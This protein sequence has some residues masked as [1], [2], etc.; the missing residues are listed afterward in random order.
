M[1]SSDSRKLV[2]ST[3]AASAHL[4]WLTT[5]QVAHRCLG[6]PYGLLWEQDILVRLMRISFCPVDKYT[7]YCK[8][9]NK[10]CGFVNQ[11]RMTLL[12]KILFIQVTSVLENRWDRASGDQAHSLRLRLS[13]MLNTSQKCQSVGSHHSFCPS[14]NQ[15]VLFYA[16]RTHQGPPWKT[17]FS[18]PRM[19]PFEFH[20]YSNRPV[21]SLLN[22]DY[23]SELPFDIKK[24]LQMIPS[25][26][27]GPRHLFLGALQVVWWTAR[28]V[29]HSWGFPI[30]IS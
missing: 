3:P 19:W 16:Q 14:F 10:Q 24:K 28:L 11:C 12:S 9:I 8:L 22:L 18:L 2:E 29:S 13:I 23:L 4:P 17:N 26:G 20:K 5:P 30:W 15:H 6:F 21:F 1:E 25:L 27:I 7:S